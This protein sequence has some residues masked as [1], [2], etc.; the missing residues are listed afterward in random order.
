M[1]A[2]FQ[3]A[4]RPHASAAATALP[5]PAVAPPAPVAPPPLSI[6]PTS[7]LSPAPISRLRTDAPVV[8]SRERFEPQEAQKPL[9]LDAVADHVLERLRS[10]LRDGRERL[11]FLLDDSH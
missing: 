3:A 6:A 9:D 11:G 1:L 8:A 5:V 4:G 2:A 7:H 10:E